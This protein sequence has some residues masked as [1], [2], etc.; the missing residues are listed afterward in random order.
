MKLLVD[1]SVLAHPNVGIAAFTDGLVRALDELPGLDLTVVAP[2]DAL[3]RTS[4]VDVPPSAIS[5][6][7]RMRWREANVHR[8][9]RDAGADVVLVPN[10]ELPL[11]PLA[12]PSAIVVHDVFPLT[13][14]ALTGR[15]KRIRF[16]LMLP[17]MC[18]RADAIV[19]VSAATRVALHK[20]VGL[21]AAKT[22]V[23][24]EGPTPMAGGDP[25]VARSTPYLL[26]AGEVFKRK[27]LITLLTAL[28]GG[29]LELVLVGRASAEARAALERQCR[30]L[31]VRA[32]HLGFVPAGE[33]RQLYGGAT[34]LALPSVDEGFG[35]PL[36]DAM[37]LGTPAIVSDI[38][39]LR[40]LGGDAPLYVGDPLDAGAW[41]AAIDRL[42]GDEA[43]RGRLV[44]RGRAR[45]KAFAWP[46]VAAR[47]RRLL[48]T[49]V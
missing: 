9:V 36:L 47:Y 6:A 1:A 20:A 28:R 35:R 7:V 46:D 17:Y 40:E 5:P 23:I 15:P 44:R 48:E 33:L 4:D 2:R 3:S 24:G 13:A 12:V 43:L 32:H 18:R 31:G 27:N 11:R 30:D 34:A 45:A 10:P 41:R 39:A 19:C 14:P 49:L 16:R 42:R 25:M 8:I 38:A 21:D 37:A 22:H 26:Y 29:D